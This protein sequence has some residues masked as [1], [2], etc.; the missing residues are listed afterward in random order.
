[1]YF[2]SLKLTFFLRGWRRGRSVNEATRHNNRA[3]VQN[4]LS[5]RKLGGRWRG[6]GNTT[7][8]PVDSISAQNPIPIGIENGE[9][10]PLT[11]HSSQI[12]MSEFADILR[13][14][15][16]DENF[17]AANGVEHTV[18]Q[19]THVLA[20]RKKMLEHS[21]EKEL[22]EEVA[23]NG[24]PDNPKDVFTKRLIA[25]PNEGGRHRGR[26]DKHVLLE[27]WVIEGNIEARSFL[28]D[29]EGTTDAGGGDGQITVNLAGRESC[30][31]GILEGLF[32]VRGRYE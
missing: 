12:L 8:S 1:M 20:G 5:V 7:R 27:W 21:L 28:C 29:R 9:R 25:S 13:V 2:E 32:H 19:E 3:R 14:H 30:L 16:R 17:G 15:R 26:V 11:T 10:E 6:G 22:G 24:R 4:V 18:I 31:G 23:I